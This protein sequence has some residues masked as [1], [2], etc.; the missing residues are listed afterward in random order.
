MKL[1]AALLGTTSLVTLAQA[2]ENTT[3]VSDLSATN[4]STVD[5]TVTFTGT[6]S[7]ANGNVG[8][9][10]GLSAGGA[11]GQASI[12]NQVQGVVGVLLPDN[13][14]VGT[15]IT[16]ENTDT[17]DVTAT[18]TAFTGNISIGTGTSN[19]IFAGSTGASGAASINQ[20][21]LAIG[22]ST[23]NKNTVSL[24][25]DIKVDNAGDSKLNVNAISGT[26]T[27]EPGNS[28]AVTFQATGAGGGGS[29]SQSIQTATADS[30]AADNKVDIQNITV[31]N[32]NGGV[33]TATVA[34]FADA[35]KIVGGVTNAV[36]V[37]AAGAAGSAS[38]TQA[39]Q[40]IT[41][42]A[43]TGNNSVIAKAI[44]VENT[45]AVTAD[46]SGFTKALEITAGVG[47]AVSVQSVGASGSA[48]IS[49]SIFTTATAPTVNNNTVEVTTIA[50]DNSGA[51][52]T[53]N[54]TF[55]DTTTITA[56]TSNL[57]SVS[58]IG[59]S[60]AASIT[61]S[62]LGTDVATV[63]GANKVTATGAMTVANT[64]TVA[65]TATFTGNVAIS[66]GVANSIGVQ[67]IGAVAAA[68][69]VARHAN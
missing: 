40:D 64:F 26:V 58:A 47:N 51:V 9:S 63:Y 23:L 61:Q 20:T 56:G 15:K 66:A 49:Q 39:L 68:S 60:G 67:S 62:T 11:I 57:V 24:A 53:K 54:V 16:A 45:R 6:T 14:V 34:T 2:A 10:I 44:D 18:V 12:T 1:A 43:L 30:K 55:A 5:A 29:I 52:E 7:I 32:A 28:N 25:G 19:R 65:S 4:S 41:A 27:L 17:G 33:V 69:V 50:V 21:A 38:I 46:A 48:G 22:A 31:T 3:T 36:S 42:S 59:A 37:Q 35:V 13:S 8:S